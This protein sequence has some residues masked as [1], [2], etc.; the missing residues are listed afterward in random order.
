MAS[1]KLV[2]PEYK[3]HY[4]RQFIES[5]TE[6]A[7]TIYYTFV[8]KPTQYLLGDNVIDTPNSDIES[9]TTRVYDEMIFAKQIT[10][11]DVKPLISR[12]DWTT[13]TVYDM[14]DS[15]DK[16]LKD[17][18]FFVV[19]K[20]GG[21][22]YVFKCLYNNEGVPSISQPIFS[23]TSADDVYYE[24]ADGYIWKYMY[25]IDETTFNKFSTID[26]IPV[27][28]DANVSSNAISGEIDVIKIE[29][30]GKDYN[31][32]LSGSFTASD[33]RF[34]GVAT[35][36]RITSPNAA[37]NTDFYE[38]CILKIVSG[39][40]IGQYRKI[41]S[42]DQIEGYYVVTINEP[43]LTT[44]TTS[45][46]EI[47]PEVIIVGDGRQTVNAEA[48]A[49]I[50]A[51]ASNTIYKIEI[52]NKG[53]DYF[54]ATANT[55]ANPIAKLSN[56]INQAKLRVIYSPKGGHGYD[57][58]SELFATNMG[59]SVKFS[60]NENGEIS[61]DNDFRTVGI[62]KDPKF[63]DVKLTYDTLAGVGFSDGEEI[64]Q[65][66]L[67]RINGTVGVDIATKNIFSIGTLTAVQVTS[68]GNVTYSNSDIVTVSN[69]VINATASAV[70]NSTGYIQSV[71][72]TSAGYGISDTASP[73][74]T[75][76]NSTGGNTR[77][78]NSRIIT[79]LTAA[80]NG[81]A[82]HNNDIIQIS[83]TS[84]IVNAIAILSTNATGGIAEITLTNSG[85]GFACN[86]IAYLTITNA[87]RGYDSTVNNQL[88]FTGG[89]GT[90]AVATFVNNATGNITSISIVSRGIG[91][92]SLPT[93]TPVTPS[94]SPTVSAVI[95]PT[96]QANGLSIKIANSSG[97]YSNGAKVIRTITNANGDIGLY[98][99]SDTLTFISASD[100]NGNAIANIV[101]NTDGSL[102]FANVNAGNNFGF[103]IGNTSLDY[104]V[105]NSSGGFKRR[106]ESKIVTN[107]VVSNNS[108]HFTIRDIRPVTAGSGY[109]NTRVLRVNIN[110]GGIGY[111]STANDI[112]VFSVGSV[113]TA[114]AYFSNDSFG[115]II[116]VT[117]TDYGNGYTSA[118]SI[119]VNPT[120]NGIGANLTAILANSITITSA[121]GGY[122]AII[123][124]SNTAAGGINNTFFIA[125]S[126]FGYTSAPTLSISDVLGTGA[127]L[128][129]DI[130]GGA[131]NI[132]SDDIFYVYGGSANAE[133]TIIANSYVSDITNLYYNNKTFS[134]A[135]EELTPTGIWFKSDGMRMFV[136][137]STGD[138]VTQYDLSTAWDITSASFVANSAAGVLR[139]TAPQDLYFTANGTTLYTTGGTGIAASNTV[140][141]F[142]L[143]QAWNVETIS[144]VANVVVNTRV[145]APTGISFKS[146]GSKLFLVGSTAPGGTGRI[147]EYDLSTP[148][149]I[150]TATYVSNT[151]P[152]GSYALTLH[153]LQFNDDGLQYYVL[154]FARNNLIQ[155]PLTQAWNIQTACS[156]LLIQRSVSLQDGS[157]A[158]IF[159]KPDQNKL[160]VVGQITDAIFEYT[161]HPKYTIDLIDSGKGFNT[162]NLKIKVANSSGGNTRFLNGTIIKEIVVTADSGVVNAFTNTDVVYVTNGNINAVG[163]AVTNS[164][165]YLTNINLT[166][167]GQ[168]FVNTSSLNMYAVNSTGG[169]VRYFNTNVV[170]SIGISDGGTGY[171]NTDY[172]IVSSPGGS[173]ARANIETTVA[174]TIVSTKLSDRGRGI[175]PWYVSELEIISGGSG[176]SNADTIEFCGGGGTGANAILLTNSSGGIVRTYV[177][178]GG[179]NYDCAPGVEVVTSTG[180]SANIVAKITKSTTLRVY[181]ANGN[182]SIGQFADLSLI[183]KPSPTLIANLVYAPTI[184]TTNEIVTLS[185]PAELEVVVADSANL[186]FTTTQAANLSL[187]LSDN[188]TTFDSSIDAGDQIYLQTL[189][190]SQV[191]TVQEVVNSTYLTV[192]EFPSFTNTAAAISVAKVNAKGNVKE[193]GVNYV[194]VTNA[195]GFFVNSNNIIG[196][197][198]RSYA[199]VL[200][201]S[202]NEVVKSGTNVDQ[203]FTYFV[204][205]GN[206]TN[207]IED[208]IVRDSE[209]TYA[210][211]HSAN[212]TA[213]KVVR[214]SG[215]FLAGSTIT[216]DDSQVSVVL[217]GGSTYKYEGDFVRGSGDIIYIENIEPIS[218]S[219]TQSETIKLILEF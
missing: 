117:M 165:N 38:G 28:P 98:A 118:P 213:F 81:L 102:N 14:Y 167:S 178:T 59:V 163:N 70:T 162:A 142:S 26:Y 112:I 69:V 148:W 72:L 8:G 60:N 216:G 176:Y 94:Y 215:V 206:P 17:K 2:T 122:G 149:D 15:L 20:E 33:V 130:I 183:V 19:S 40:G 99:N 187:I 120:A 109:N 11:N 63:N 86:E 192:T 5:I 143:A 181:N 67:N 189:N 156:S 65:A 27:I 159:V 13:G 76:A 184:G 175:V 103:S 71:P 104:F 57:A 191:L 42:Y 157:P 198:S 116:T 132:S 47:S 170:S 55:Y 39:D 108:P 44:P 119:T 93:I 218:R 214:L 217:D 168:G 10:A 18:A 114:N 56:T 1:N 91:Y 73:V 35:Q 88:A 83:S 177:V 37:S 30:G 139:Q 205:S 90:G 22:F 212:S 136:I 204:S 144:Y 209:G 54:L 51:V 82:Y 153:S 208:E 12:H 75:V 133:G 85:K 48:R 158:G 66:K 147:N 79:G 169:D 36:F 9:L 101:T 140:V 173:V 95:T 16:N 203:L 113:T 58:E 52:L 137:G 128:E 135:S 166:I 180:T 68:S 49:L 174:G 7:N 199:N 50:N 207:F 32:F 152:L 23:A 121:T 154:D 43:F 77:Y 188:R 110:D 31:N 125:N 196:V 193:R 124:F 24:T 115:K 92:T 138:D 97:G 107:V 200:Q 164:T 201:I 141:S 61:T 150:T 211:I 219:N 185:T 123:Y 186:F 161:I 195:S 151:T 202:Y 87:G 34:N 210:Y 111:D 4:I 190:E 46:F 80:A 96:L 100:V 6:P 74:I 155:V 129:A 127:V 160:W 78:F 182:P 145:P 25:K 171:S 179:E 106:F 62:L 3:L 29:S 134:I 194:Q 131:N 172:I 64:I 89:G 197:S 105:A 41:V 146:D 126:G 45:T 84:A 21:T 53:K